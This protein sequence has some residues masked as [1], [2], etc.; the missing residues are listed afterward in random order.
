MGG[1]AARARTLENILLRSSAP[2][3]PPHPRC[4]LHLSLGTTVQG[5]RSSDAIQQGLPN[6]PE[7]LKLRGGSLEGEFQAQTFER[8][9][10][11]LL[12]ERTVEL[13]E[14]RMTGDTGEAER[15][16]SLCSPRDEQRTS[17]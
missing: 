7:R 16:P 17:T 12:T 8:R 15:A 14:Q 11:E 9:H 6:G 1:T 2:L 10:P 3:R 13:D 5:L 4:T